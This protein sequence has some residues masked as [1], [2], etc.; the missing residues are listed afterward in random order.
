MHCGEYREP[1][2]AHVDG[3]LTP[4]EQATVAAHIAGCPTCT[5]LLEREQQ[6]ARSLRGRKLIRPVVS[7]MLVFVRTATATPSA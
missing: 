2:A 4:E 1:T 5:R 6:F 3:L 7:E